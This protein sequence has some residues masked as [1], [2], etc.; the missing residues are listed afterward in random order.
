LPSMEECHSYVA[1]RVGCRVGGML[2]DDRQPLE[3][4][5]TNPCSTRA[6]LRERPPSNPAA[7]GSNGCGTEISGHQGILL[8]P[9]A[10]MSARLLACP[11]CARHIRMTE[12]TCPFCAAR[13]PVSFATACA[14]SLLPLPGRRSRA[15]WFHLGARAAA[16]VGGGAAIAIALTCCD[17]SVKALYGGPP[18]DFPPHEPAAASGDAGTF[19]AEMDGGALP[20]TAPGDAG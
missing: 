13:C 1:F 11:S 12:A 19:S 4:S 20:V 2:D 5:T 7:D 14:A 8:S 10:P 15:G 3:A 18:P 17:N 9:I 16:G 6:R